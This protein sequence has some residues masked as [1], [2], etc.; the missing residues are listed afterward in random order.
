MAQNPESEQLDLFSGMTSAKAAPKIRS[1]RSTQAD[2]WQGDLERE[3][4][5]P[6]LVDL[7]RRNREL[8]KALVTAGAPEGAP[9][10]R[11]FRQQEAPLIELLM[12]LRRGELD[13][14]R[15]DVAEAL[16]GTVSELAATRQ[17]ILEGLGP[18]PGYA[19]PTTSSTRSSPR[20]NSRSRRRGVRSSRS[21]SPSLRSCR[22]HSSVWPTSK[23]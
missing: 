12:L 2:V 17:R 19:S 16:S 13:A 18:S 6:V 23:R 15:N 14:G 4:L 20:S 1:W 22:R 10:V 3:K 11:S 21:R 8:V 5:E 9:E 7:L